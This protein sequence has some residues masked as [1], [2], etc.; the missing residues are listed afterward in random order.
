MNGYADNLDGQL[1]VVSFP[2]TTDCQGRDF[3]KENLNTIEKKMLLTG[4][5]FTPTHNKNHRSLWTFAQYRL[6]LIFK[7]ALIVHKGSLGTVGWFE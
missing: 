1:K 5:L 4:K 3:N 6:E 7:D 2:R